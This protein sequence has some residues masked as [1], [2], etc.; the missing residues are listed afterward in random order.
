MW[1][2]LL[3]HLSKA[4]NTSDSPRWFRY[5]FGANTGYLMYDSLSY[6]EVRFN[7]P[8]KTFDKISLIGGASLLGYALP[9]VSFGCTIIIGHNNYILNTLLDGKDYWF[10]KYPDSESFTHHNPLKTITIERNSQIR[11][12]KNTN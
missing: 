12:D 4:P 10:N 7:Q 8:P 6:T 5:F 1:K 9:Y 2:R 3:E 11:D